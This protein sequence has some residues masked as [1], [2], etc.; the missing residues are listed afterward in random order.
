MPLYE[1]QRH[2]TLAGK[3]WDEGAARAA[4]ERIAADARRCFGEDKLWPIHPLD[5]REGR[6]QDWYKAL[7]IGAA[8]VIW[9]LDYLSKTGAVMAGDEYC[10][11]VGG[12]LER[13]RADF[14]TNS[15]LT[16]YLMGDAGIL[17][18]NWKLAP[19]R[20]VAQQAFDEIKA[21]I[22]NSVREFMWGAPGTMLAALFMFEWTAEER[23]KNLFLRNCEQLLQE[24]EFDTDSHSHLWT[25]NLYG[26]SVKLLG[27][28][29]GF[30]GNVFPLIRGRH[31]LEPSTMDKWL[32]HICETLE[33]TALREGEHV[34]WPQSVGVPR[35]GRTAQLVQHCHGAPGVINCL[36][37]FP[38]DPR[39]PVDALLNAAGELTWTAGP[40]AK[41]PGLCHG[42]AGNG[43]AFLKLYK[44]TGDEKW[45]DR[46][47]K[48]A[49]HAIEQS[50]R[51]AKEFGQHRYSLWTGDLGLAVYLWDCVRGIPQFPTMDVF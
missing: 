48:F 10:S 29:H 37:E 43:Y 27:A 7:Y 28:V 46:A 17:L 24:L 9:V 31:L 1:P 19:A 35:P 23:W 33:R 38:P 5:W 39:W 13:N 26:H 6:P 20:D 41:G 4:I 3:P 12:L 34:N 42:S 44:R 15:Q 11:W 49:M 21:N 32:A 18:L 2:E 50:E 36:A 16:S 8:G 25:Q 14:P 22:N 30:A 51:A 47:R 45:L 40:L